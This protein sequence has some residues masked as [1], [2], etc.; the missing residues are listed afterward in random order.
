MW[1]DVDAGSDANW[2][3]AGIGGKKGAM[4]AAVQ[5]GCLDFAW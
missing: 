5:T 4:P 2:N 3:S 1:N